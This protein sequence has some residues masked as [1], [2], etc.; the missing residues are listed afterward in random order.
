MEEVWAA[1]RQLDPAWVPG[2]VAIA[3][4]VLAWQTMREQTRNSRLE[5]IADVLMDC[6]RRYG[7][8]IALRTQ[9]EAD[10]RRG[11]LS[12]SVAATRYF[13]A[14]WNLQ[15]DQYNY[16]Q[17]GLLPHHVIAI[18]FLDRVRQI[19]RGETVFGTSFQNGWSDIARDI[20]GEYAEFV[21]FVDE[22]WV[23]A[24]T[25]GADPKET[26]DSLLKEH[27]ALGRRMRVDFTRKSISRG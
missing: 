21:R 23:A 26:I 7:D 25:D 27:F 5:K 10:V 20:L 4:L 22:V 11:E 1:I 17:L 9:L 13:H 12:E 24:L 6:T 15:W 16:F 14:Y 2:L 19:R 3:A 8:L 18:W